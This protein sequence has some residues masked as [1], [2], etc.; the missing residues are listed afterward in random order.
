MLQ[1]EFLNVFLDCPREMIMPMELLEL[2]S[3]QSGYWWHPHKP[4]I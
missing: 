1:L 4:L 3:V 2:H